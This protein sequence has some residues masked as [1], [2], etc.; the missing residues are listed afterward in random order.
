[1]VL[2]KESPLVHDHLQIVD[3][4]PPRPSPPYLGTILND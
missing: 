2:R 4:L 1:M 3:R